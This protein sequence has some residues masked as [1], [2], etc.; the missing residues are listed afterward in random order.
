M[1][2]ANVMT[3]LALVHRSAGNLPSA[4]TLLTMATETYTAALG[5]AHPD[6]AMT[7]VLLGECFVKQAAAIVAE[8]QGNPAGFVA[9]LLFSS[10]CFG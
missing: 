8:Q 4:I 3:G 1:Q 5:A 6:V 2:V 10:A 9:V 7:R